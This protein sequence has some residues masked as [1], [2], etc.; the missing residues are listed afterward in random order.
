[1]TETSGSPDR[2]PSSSDLPGEHLSN[3]VEVA[4]RAGYAAK[5]LVYAVIGGLAVQQAIGRGGDTTGSREALREIAGAPFGQAILWVV[6]VGLAAYMVWRLVQAFLDPEGDS[7]DDGEA[8]RW[9]VRAFYLMSAVLYGVLAW[10]ALDLATGGAGGGQG[11]GG[12]GGGGSSGWAAKLM[13]MT[14]GVWLVGAVGIGIVAR[15]LLQFFKAYTDS[16]KEKI[17][18]HDLDA[19]TRRWVLRISRLGLTAR[20]VV[21][22]II[23][24]SVVYAAV[25]HD[26]QEA[27]GL[28]GALNVLV[29]SP[30]LLGAVGGGLVAYAVY[31][32]V[33]A[34]YRLIGA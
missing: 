17:S 1:M 10:Y 14:W 12:G 2:S 34:R 4:A 7:S 25:Q 20:G 9:G 13:G 27:R 33:K 8:K 28:E 18:A 5:G 19:T 23:G 3:G 29:Q 32:W 26:P 24:S 21:F 16:F 15:G 30:W 31:Q 6:V 22:G 11:A